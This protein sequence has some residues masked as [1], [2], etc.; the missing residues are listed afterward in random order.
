LHC[1]SEVALRGGSRPDQ[2][3]ALSRVPSLLAGMLSVCQS[4]VSVPWIFAAV[5]SM[6]T[7]E[8]PCS[9][10]PVTIRRTART[11]LSSL[12]IESSVVPASGRSSF[13]ER[14]DRRE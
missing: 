1:A 3:A 12:P 6:R 8:S 13:P 5:A 11:I 14:D 2:F 4:S 9:S 7:C 10:E